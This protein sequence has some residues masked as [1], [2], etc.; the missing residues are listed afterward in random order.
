MY[1]FFLI[2]VGFA[3]LIAGANLLVDGASSIARKLKIPDL[4]IGLTIVAFGTSAPE[5]IVNILASFKQETDLSIGNVTGSNIFNIAAILGLSAL[6]KPPSVKISTILFEIPLSLLAAVVL[7]VLAG[8]SFI[9]GESA[10]YLTRTDG[11]LLLLFFSIFMYYTINMAL[12][13]DGNEEGIPEK[14]WTMPVSLLMLTGGLLLLLV[15]GQ[16]IV[17]SAVSLA[18]ILGI[19]E[20]IIALTIVSIGTS[21]PELA[22][23]LIAAKKGNSDLAVGN[24]VG[25]NIFNIFFI[26]GVSAIISPLPVHKEFLS[27]FIVNLALNVM[28]LVFAFSGKERKIDKKEGT[29]LLLSYFAYTYFLIFYK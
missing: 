14:D 19:S 16:F 4:V 7:I 22:T 26:L 25:S 24:V 13:S 8:D 17:D 12:N 10:A 21:L 29:V 18:R 3:A 5:L 27:D 1:Y 23:S 11:I 28:L 15:G 6:L 9:N 20:R 2:L